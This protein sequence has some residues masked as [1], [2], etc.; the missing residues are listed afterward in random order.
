MNPQAKIVLDERTEA[1]PAQ[2]R[3]T[4]SGEAGTSLSAEQVYT[5]RLAE[6]S[7]N[8]AAGAAAA[9]AFIP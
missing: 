9:P 8:S 1:H 4:T 7:L 3:V 6:T 2:E 5:Q